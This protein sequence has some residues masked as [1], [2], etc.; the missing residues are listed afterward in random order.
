MIGSTR[1]ARRAG[2]Q[3][4]PSATSTSSATTP[5]NVSGSRG[6]TPYSRLAASC[7]A[8]RAPIDAEHDADERRRQPVPHREAADVLGPRAE[9]HAN[10]DLVRALRD[11]VA[12]H[13]RETDGREHQCDHGE[14]RQQRHVEPR[15]RRSCSR[16]PSRSAPRSVSRSRD[17]ALAS[18]LR[19]AAMATAG[20]PAART[21]SVRLGGPAPGNEPLCLERP[22]ELRRVALLHQAAGNDVVDDTDDGRPVAPPS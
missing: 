2:N 11:L 17:R 10:A 8:P 5:T 19:S 21:I 3:L 14:R 4:A 18:R 6:A 12:D 13:G 15:R 22:V 16:A 20:S 7:V 9:R 1:V